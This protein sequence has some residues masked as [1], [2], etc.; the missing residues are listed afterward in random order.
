MRYMLLIDATVRRGRA[1]VRPSVLERLSQRLTA[2][3]E[4]VGAGLVGLPGRLVRA[5]EGA[6]PVLVE[7]TEGEDRLGG[8][9]LVDC[10]DLERAVAIAAQLCLAADQ[11]V[12]VRRVMGRPGEEM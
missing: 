8:Y 6:A 5:R 7:I 3:G 11:P 2:S 10:E 1:R 9:L 12:E 4:L